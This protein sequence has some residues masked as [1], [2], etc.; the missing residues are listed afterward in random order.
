MEHLPSPPKPFANIKVPFLGKFFEE[1]GKDFARY[2]SR[3]GWDQHTAKKT[4]E[5]FNVDQHLLLTTLQHAQN[6]LG[7]LQEQLDSKPVEHRETLRECTA[8]LS[9]EA[10]EHAPRHRL[11]RIHGKYQRKI[12]EARSDSLPLSVVSQYIGY[13]RMLELL[14]VFTCER[15][16]QE[17]ETFASRRLND[18][19]LLTDAIRLRWPFWVLADR[20]DQK[21]WEIRTAFANV[22]SWLYFGMLLR[23]FS[24]F[25][26]SIRQEDYID[27]S[28][29]YV[30]TKILPKHLS[31]WHDLH[32]DKDNP[33]PAVN[34]A[35]PPIARM[36]A[37]AV[38]QTVSTF[39]ATGSRTMRTKEDFDAYFESNNRLTG[40]WSSSE[41]S[42]SV[43]TLTELLAI[44]SIPIYGGE[45]CGGLGFPSSVFLLH[46]FEA[47]GW[48]PRLIYDMR[49]HNIPF[50][51]YAYLLGPPPG[52]TH[53]TSCTT[54]SCDLAI[55][56]DT[57][58]RFK[59]DTQAK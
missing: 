3:N 5:K 39:V 49:T 22:Q 48:C 19:A 7:R 18:L 25:G 10:N 57:N 34:V 41:I 45:I 58:Y 4:I 30:S 37:G 27:P 32:A 35:K 42:F 36:I 6:F 15:C 52:R 43:A 40:P 33:P 8:F 47:D 29:I 44:A 11:H 56:S 12:E 17:K 21:L 38:W 23:T 14:A 50:Q 28:G 51:Y 2:P 9:S 53:H 59:H 26:I 13:C 55:I 24:T 46:R 54:D 16:V 20:L 1:D 31:A